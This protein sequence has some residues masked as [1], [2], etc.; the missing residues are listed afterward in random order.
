[1][2]VRW[3]SCASAVTSDAA[4]PPGV[5]GAVGAVCAPGPPLGVK[6]M[7]ATITAATAA[8]PASQVPGRGMRGCDADTGP[9]SPIRRRPRR[10]RQDLDVRCWLAGS[11]PVASPAADRPG[12]EVGGA[13]YL[14]GVRPGV[15]DGTADGD[16][17]R[18]NRGRHRLDRGTDTFGGSGGAFL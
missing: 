4:S 16:A 5:E 6:V 10:G 2:R 7:T 13:P 9:V 11:V 15:P 18:T 3:M 8:V 12:S 17:G 14:E 1:M